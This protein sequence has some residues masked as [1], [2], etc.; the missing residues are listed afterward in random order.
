MHDGCLVG[1]LISERVWRC[2][3]VNVLQQQQQHQRLTVITN[4]Q[5]MDPLVYC[6]TCHHVLSGE[7]F[8]S[9]RRSRRNRQHAKTTNGWL[10]AVCLVTVLLLLLPSAQWCCV[11]FAGLLRHSSR[12]SE[13]ESCTELIDRPNNVGKT[14]AVR[15]VRCRSPW[16]RSLAMDTLEASMPTSQKLRR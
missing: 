13:Y 11:S 8:Q 16:S 15:V 2:F 14:H 3:R 12:A 1:W 7:L 6:R 10:V 4:K 9:C 5:V